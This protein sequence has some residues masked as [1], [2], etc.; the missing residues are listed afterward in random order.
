MKSKEFKPLDEKI[1]EQRDFEGG[2]LNY[3]FIDVK[4]LKEHIQILKERCATFVS[5]GAIV[6]VV[7][8]VFGI[9]LSIKR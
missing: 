7:N 4:D 6:T 8:E 2:H 9:K 3:K 1:H 5:A